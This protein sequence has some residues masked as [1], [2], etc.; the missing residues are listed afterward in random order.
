MSRIPAA[1][2]CKTGLSQILAGCRWTWLRYSSRTRPQIACFGHQPVVRGPRPEGAVR[3]E[4]DLTGARPARQAFARL[5]RHILVC[6]GLG[7]TVIGLPQHGVGLAVSGRLLLVDLGT[8]HHHHSN[9]DYKDN[10]NGD[11]RTVAIVVVRA[12]LTRAKV[13]SRL[14][15]ALRR[16]D[17]IDERVKDVYWG[18]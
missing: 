3:V 1:L 12:A 15:K 6:G 17:V 14:P 18:P 13:V 9:Q 4:D 11:G 2:P 8:G 16:F 10:D 7:L 5:V